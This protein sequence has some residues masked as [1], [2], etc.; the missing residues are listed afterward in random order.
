V[1]GRRTCESPNN[2]QG[3]KQPIS[4]PTSQ[5]HCFHYPICANISMQTY[6]HSSCLYRAWLWLSWSA[7]LP[8]LVQLGSREHFSWVP[9]WNLSSH[10]WAQSITSR[11]LRST[12]ILSSHL[13]LSFLNSYFP[14]DFPSKILYTFLVLVQLTRCPRILYL[15]SAPWATTN[16]N[17]KSPFVKCSPSSR[18]LPYLFHS[19]SFPRHSTLEHHQ[20]IFVP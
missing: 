3:S 18:F 2:K 20:L 11:S 5:F 4:C 6:S 16:T 1:A 14:S 10:T 17:P 12:S 9:N 13:Q 19:N 15:N 8:R 7:Q